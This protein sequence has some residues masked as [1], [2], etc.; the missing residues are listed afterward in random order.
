MGQRVA[1]R[2]GGQSSPQAADRAGA[3][4]GAAGHALPAPTLA[5]EGARSEPE[6]RA[7]IDAP[8]APA[9]ASVGVNT[10]GAPLPYLA[11]IQRSFGHHD[12]SDTQAHVG[13]GASAAAL[14]L[15]ARAYATGEHA[16]FGSGA[17]LSTAAHEAA[18]VVQQRS[19]GIPGGMGRAGDAWE[20]HADAVA[21]R[22]VAGRS[23]QALLD[24]PPSGSGAGSSGAAPVQ[25]QPTS[26]PTAAPAPPVAPEM[27]I[28]QL[29]SGG[30]AGTDYDARKDGSFASF[31]GGLQPVLD[32]MLAGW[33]KDPEVKDLLPPKPGTSGDSSG[34]D[35]AEHPDWVQRFQRKLMGQAPRGRDLDFKPSRPPIGMGK[36]WDRQ[37]EIAQSLIDVYMH[38]WYRRSVRGA[39]L[40]T[41]PNADG[42]WSPD[43]L[44]TDLGTQ[45]TGLRVTTTDG[46]YLRWNGT[47]WA[48][49]TRDVPVNVAE[50]YER[51]GA[52]ETNDQSALL[53][54][55]AG[56]P[57]WCGPASE[58]AVG[59]ALMKRGLRFKGS[60]NLR[61]PKQAGR[62]VHPGPPPPAPVDKKDW[63]AQLA[64]NTE[65]AAYRKKESAYRLAVTDVVESFRAEVTAQG[66]FFIGKWIS[67]GVSGGGEKARSN[68][69]WRGVGGKSAGTVPLEPGDYIYVI[70][71]GGGPLSG[72]VATVMDERPVLDPRTWE[73]A[74]AGAVLSHLYWISGNARGVRA[75]EGAV[76]AEV[77]KRE[78]PH[79][80]F[81]YYLTAGIGNEADKY[82]DQMSAA[83]RKERG[84]LQTVYA[85][86]YIKVAAAIGEQI[87]LD[88]KD[89]K[90]PNA[91]KPGKTALEIK[92]AVLWNN[93]L[94]RPTRAVAR[95]SGYFGSY[96]AWEQAEPLLARMEAAIAPI[97]K[98]EAA[99]KK[100][101]EEDKYKGAE[102]KDPKTKEVVGHKETKGHPFARDEA[103]DVVNRKEGG[104]ATGRFA[105]L[106]ADHS[107]VV[108]V[109]K[110]SQFSRAAE[111]YAT[112]RAATGTSALG[113]AE[114]ARA[115]GTDMAAAS[116]AATAA[117]KA[118]EQKILDRY[119]LE[120]MSGDIESN[121]PG[122]MAYWET[123]GAF[124]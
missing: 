33:D 75:Y 56:G 77:V 42:L 5:W 32:Y 91:K 35:V 36:A 103:F 7:G 85:K 94:A 97:L 65:M 83:T 100:S 96:P 4:A 95:L 122:A 20:R 40:A 11:Q 108:S 1:A 69:D 55:K 86:G 109:V 73:S 25:L 39:Q 81:D 18:H 9:I 87:W 59:L 6:A 28:D 29:L 16:V 104:G 66:A 50:L 38:A 43:A 98:E 107:W 22:V 57:N 93:V 49:A 62:P 74:P 31:Q 105:P 68:P 52:S 10:P 30:F 112:A 8:D 24:H 45:Q 106:I 110:A 64:H 53:G 51:I 17:S 117:G 92:A 76:R 111:E 41:G 123:T 12:V 60:G 27:A 61:L 23:A 21:E 99:F 2:A 102:K 124:R 3:G 44:P 118:E 67:K 82:K 88:E 19:A 120:P 63:K 79:G 78:K 89:S 101:V 70:N 14:A 37:S 121:W 116:Q 113:A 47:A 71:G 15:G 34:K 119:T 13:P 80:D 48:P 114:A 46:R 54:G 90:A 26:A 84:D 115:S 72:H 58:R